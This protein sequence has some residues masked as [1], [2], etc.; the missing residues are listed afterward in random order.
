MLV[1]L[2]QPR[3]EE[4]FELVRDHLEKHHLGKVAG[5]RIVLTGGASQLQGVRDL[6]VL[7][8]EKQVRLGRP[9]GFPHAASSP[10]FAAATGLLL[11]GLSIKRD[12]PEPI[13]VQGG[14]DLGMVGKIGHWLKRNF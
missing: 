4:T 12:I 6:A 11:H 7:I 2:I 14:E 3:I 10:A 13:A 8:L 9:N 1:Q 5:R